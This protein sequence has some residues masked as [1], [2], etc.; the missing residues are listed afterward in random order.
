MSRALPGLHAFSGC[1]SISAF[2]GIGK[3]K[4]LN[5][6]KENELYRDALCQLGE[7]AEI[8]QTVFACIEQMVCT[9]YG[10]KDDNSIDDVRYTKC[11]GK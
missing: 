7:S 1:D 6:V 4:W 2:N 3:V 5:L 8:H 10:F 9:A 11:C